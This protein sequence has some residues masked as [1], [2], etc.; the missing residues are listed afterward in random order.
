LGRK[1]LLWRGAESAKIKQKRKGLQK[2]IGHEKEKKKEKIC[3]SN[4]HTT[5]KT[6]DS[7]KQK[8]KEKEKGVVPNPH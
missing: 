8:K 4:V 6:K 7:K 5:N 2:I 1:R 3:I